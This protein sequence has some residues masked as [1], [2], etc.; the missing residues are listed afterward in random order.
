MALDIPKRPTPI[1]DDVIGGQGGDVMLRFTARDPD[2]DGF[3][4]VKWTIRGGMPYVFANP[5]PEDPRVVF[6]EVTATDFNTQSHTQTLSLRRVP[7]TPHVMNVFID[8]EFFET[9]KSGAPLVIGGHELPPIPNVVVL[10]V[11]K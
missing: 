4:R 10:T 1:P 6:G 9:D 3:F 11:N 7:G 5:S 2:A 8:V